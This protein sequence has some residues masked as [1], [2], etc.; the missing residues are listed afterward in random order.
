MV[1]FGTSS[2]RRYLLTLIVLASITMITLDERADDKGPLGIVGRVVHRVA[3]P[4]S[5]AA[6][7]IFGSVGDWVSGIT[8]GGALRDQNRELRVAVQELQA[9]VRDADRANSENEKFRELF[10]LPWLDDIP[11]VAAVVTSG[12]VGN[13]EESV[14][15]NKGTE[16]GISVGFPVVGPSGL[17]GRVI[18]SW[19]GG[20]K[21][22]LVSDP[23]FGVTV[24][25][26]DQGITGP[27]EGQSGTKTLKLNLSSADLTVE[28]VEA[29]VAGDRIET[30]GCFDSEFPPG[31]PVGDVVATE[32]QTSG[33]SIIVKI[34]PYL[35]RAS[36]SH[37]KVLLWDPGDAVPAELRATTT[38][39]PQSTS[40]TD[41][42]VGPYGR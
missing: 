13:Y 40:V 25:L 15:L 7:N 26:L 9:K 16:A 34:R 11:T 27:A 2:R 8:D 3:E 21:V 22:L 20:S 6:S 38:T 36:L 29:I 37:V 41:I 23:T 17:V 12:S 10:G 28:Q 19:T 30:C 24:R 42:T 1:R 14:I 33:I 32:R 18:D 4:I 31:I 39:T 35:D 5:G